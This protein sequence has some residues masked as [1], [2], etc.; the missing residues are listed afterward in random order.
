[1]VF[2]RI[3]FL[4]FGFEFYEI[5]KSCSVA[6]RRKVNITANFQVTGK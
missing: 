4:I 2:I 3:L 6:K 5:V 1:M